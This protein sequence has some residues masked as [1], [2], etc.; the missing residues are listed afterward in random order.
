M[1]T[2]KKIAVFLDDERV[3]QFVSN[4]IPNFDS[5]EWIVIRNYFEFT[6]FVDNN[7]ERI[8]LVSFDHDIDS[9]DESGKEWNGKD[10]ADYLLDVCMDNKLNLPDFIVHSMNPIGK[11][12]IIGLYKNYLD[13]VEGRIDRESWTDL[14]IGIIDGELILQN[15][16]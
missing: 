3:P 5:Y 13:K 1:Q 4:K 12:N 15:L 7:L 14:H 8:S 6:D 10:A 16:Q 2:N 11:G 9:F